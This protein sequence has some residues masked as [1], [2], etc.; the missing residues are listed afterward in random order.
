MK[1]F[2]NGFIEQLPF[3]LSIL[4]MIT[5]LPIAVSSGFAISYKLYG[6]PRAVHCSGK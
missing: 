5:L 1:N 3:T 2:I 4:L 6:D